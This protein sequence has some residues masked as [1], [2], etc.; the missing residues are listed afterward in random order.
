[1]FCWQNNDAPTLFAQEE[2]DADLIAESR[3]ENIAIDSDGE[4]YV[5]DETDVKGACSMKHD[6]SHSST[7][8]HIEMDPSAIDILTLPPKLHL[9]NVDWSTLDKEIDKELLKKK[10]EESTDNE[11]DSECYMYSSEDEKIRE[12]MK[13]MP[14]S[15]RKK[16]KKKLKKKKKV[17]EE[18]E[19]MLRTNDEDKKLDIYLPKN[20]KKWY[21]SKTGDVSGTHEV[22]LHINSAQLLFPYYTQVQD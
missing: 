5:V 2:D 13:K 8:P 19:E 3:N 20:L 11:S 7:R 4:Y 18:V 15:E 10:A 14:E 22:A 16:T 6:R 1:M 17:R 12:E 21:I 9:D